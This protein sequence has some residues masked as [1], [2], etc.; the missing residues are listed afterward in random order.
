MKGGTDLGNCRNELKVAPMGLSSRVLKMER[1][2]RGRKC[3]RCFDMGPYYITYSGALYGPIAP[4]PTMLPCS[5]CGRRA[6]EINIEYVG[7]TEKPG[8]SP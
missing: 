5:L 8:E 3:P 7:H 2:V 1:T 4:P 6:K